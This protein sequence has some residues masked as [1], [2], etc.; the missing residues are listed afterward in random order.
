MS[1]S[2]IYFI[3]KAAFLAITSLIALILA[4]RIKHEKSEGKTTRRGV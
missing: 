2:V 1:D 4:F 3:D